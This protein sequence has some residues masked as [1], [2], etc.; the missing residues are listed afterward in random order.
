MAYSRKKVLAFGIVGVMLALSI[1]TFLPTRRDLYVTTSVSLEEI[2]GYGIQIVRISGQKV[3]ITNLLLRISSVEAQKESGEWVEI[4]SNLE[5]DL[6]QEIVKTFK[7]IESIKGY[8][9]IRLNISQNSSAA[10]EDGGEVTLGVPSLPL[11]LQLSELY[12]GTHTEPALRLSIGQG[13]GSNYILPNLQVE[14]ST[15][16]L[17][18]EIVDQ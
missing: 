7:V 3:Q 6:Q 13:R 5:W 14:V 12:S 15:S 8:N 1:I 2:P 4:C 18:A 17:T 10:L 16:K 9:R 11:E